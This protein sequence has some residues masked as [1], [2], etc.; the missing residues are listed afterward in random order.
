[1]WIDSINFPNNK[2]S[3]KQIGKSMSLLRKYS[4][5]FYTFT[6]HHGCTTLI[7]HQI[8]LVDNV[9]VWCLD[10]TIPPQ[11]IFQVKKIINFWS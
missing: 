1:M 9:P 2:L 3:P 8:D 11:L 4:K 10:H 7:E 6:D 5:V